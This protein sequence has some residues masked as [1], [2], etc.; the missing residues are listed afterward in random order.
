MKTAFST[1]VLI[2]AAAALPCLGTAQQPKIVTV[3]EVMANPTEHGNSFV[4]IVGRLDATGTIFGRRNLISQDNCDQPVKTNGF[5]W[6]TK[7]LI[8]T[9]SEN[10]L[11]SPPTDHPQ[12]DQGTLALKISLMGKD[13]TLGV[14]KSFGW[15]K[16]A[17][18]RT[19]LSGTNG[20]P[21]MAY[22]LFTASDECCD[23]CRTRLPRLQRES[24]GRDRS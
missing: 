24:S 9:Q 15:T 7:V 8:W 17:S 13:T 19:L 11:P 12:I 3:C 21:H 20:S 18:Q 23:V 1:V 2:V 22:V 16:M 6:P 5:A 10:G 14:A 4:V